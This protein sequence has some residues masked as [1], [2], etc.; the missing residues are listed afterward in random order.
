MNWR[1][2]LYAGDLFVQSAG[3]VVFH[4]AFTRLEQGGSG[5]DP[6]T[7]AFVSWAGVVLL[8][9]S[10]MHKALVT[11][12]LRSGNATESSL[13][14]FVSASAA[15]G[16]TVGNYW[17]CVRFPFDVMRTAS[18][19]MSAMTFTF[20]VCVVVDAVALVKRHRR[21]RH[22]PELHEAFLAAGADIYYDAL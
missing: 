16:F 13:V 9:F 11:F 19:A 1:H 18:L 8:L 10:S 14:I 17:L 15:A 21:Q 3:A 12:L 4:R 5:V 6:L 20:V 22:D 2:V 7:M